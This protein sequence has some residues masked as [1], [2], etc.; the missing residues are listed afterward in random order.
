MADDCATVV[1]RGH[2][3]RGVAELGD[4]LVGL[5]AMQPAE[6][7]LLLENIAAAPSA[8]NMALPSRRAVQPLP[9]VLAVLK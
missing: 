7:H 8:Q 5:F 3:E 6:G 9:G 1:A 4:Q 2:A